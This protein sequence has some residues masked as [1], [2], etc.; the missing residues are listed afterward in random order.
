MAAVEARITTSGQM[1]LPAALRR[2]WQTNSVVVVDKGDYII[3]RPRPADVPSALK[4][5]LRAHG[6]LNADQ[7]RQA[8]RE[9]EGSSRYD[10]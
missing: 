4:G 10:R 5:S 8:E 6:P 7:M 1:S 9:A 3:V 2:R